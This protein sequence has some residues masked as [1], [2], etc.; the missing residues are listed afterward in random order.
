MRFVSKDTFIGLGAGVG[1][2]IAL[3]LLAGYILSSRGVPDPEEMQVMLQPPRFPRDEPTSMYEQA[4][5]WS[6]QTLEGAEAGLSQFKGK[7]V[8]LNFWATWCQPCV[9]EMPSI[10]RLYDTMEHEDV[11]FLLVS[12]EEKNT[13]R[14]FVDTRH[15]SFPVYLSGHDVPDPLRTRGIPATFILDRDGVVA[16][17]HVGSAKWDDESC[18][19]FLRGLLG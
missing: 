2:T 1:L 6:L 13:V 7:V 14:N 10:Q 15:Y 17:Q 12:M 5:G 9:I 19:R 16:F 8:F 18:L 11:V 3:V 4:A